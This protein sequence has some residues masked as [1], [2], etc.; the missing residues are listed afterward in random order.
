MIDAVSWEKLT[1][2]IEK[3]EEYD[4]IGIDEGQFFEDI[5]EVSEELANK[6]KTVIISALDGTFERKAFGR[7]LELV[8]LAEEV[9]KL[10]AVCM[11]CKEPAS[12]TKRL[13]ESKETE[14]IGGSEIYKPVWRRCFIW[15]NPKANTNL[16]SIDCD[17]FKEN[18]NE[19]NILTSKEDKLE[20][21][22]IPEKMNSVETADKSDTEITQELI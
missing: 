21:P 2:V 12:F 11:D 4:I 6:G 13:W 18:I 8:P 5:V 3:A 20:L 9:T 16:S 22:E 19:S 15:D 1:D 17:V 7:I 10:D 14:L